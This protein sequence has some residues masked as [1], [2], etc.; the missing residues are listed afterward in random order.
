MQVLNRLAQLLSGRIRKLV[1]FPLEALSGDSL[2]RRKTI[3]RSESERSMIENKLQ[4]VLEKRKQILKDADDIRAEI[5]EITNKRLE[6]EGRRTKADKDAQER[7]R[8]LLELQ[9]TCSALEGK[10]NAADMEEKQIL[11]KLWETTGL[12][13][14]P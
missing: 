2:S 7:N 13:A 10:K 6:L 5:S 1:V 11:D 4:E 12:R 8:E 14:A 3:E 9:K